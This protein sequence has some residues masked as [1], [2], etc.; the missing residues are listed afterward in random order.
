M[1]KIEWEPRGQGDSSVLKGPGRLSEVGYLSALVPLLL[2]CMAYE[3]SFF[4]F[5]PGTIPI[6]PV[7]FSLPVNGNLE[8]RISEAG[9]LWNQITVM[10]AL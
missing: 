9:C 2:G 10:A 8:W 5:F 1:H 4:F 3:K 6:E 7:K